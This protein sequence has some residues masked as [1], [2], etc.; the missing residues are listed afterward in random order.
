MAINQGSGRRETD[1][2]RRGGRNKTRTRGSSRSL[3]MS[4]IGSRVRSIVNHAAKAKKGEK[5]KKKGKKGDCACTQRVFCRR[6]LAPRVRKPQQQRPPSGPPLGPLYIVRCIDLLLTRTHFRRE[7]INLRPFPLTSHYRTRI[8]RRRE[9]KR[10]DRTWPELI[11]FL[12]DESMVSATCLKDNQ[13]NG[14][15]RRVFASLTVTH[16]Y[17]WR[18]RFA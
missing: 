16:M 18:W 9:S 14:P 7:S 12:A 4:G 6:G 11:P 13:N 17:S 1:K 3:P 8:R 10:G 15:I 5:K 2:E